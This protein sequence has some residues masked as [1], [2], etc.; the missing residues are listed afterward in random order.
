[1]RAAHRPDEPRPVGTALTLSL[2]GFGGGIRQVWTNREHQDD[3]AEEEGALRLGHCT[4]PTT[5]VVLPAHA[6][7]GADNPTT[8]PHKSMPIGALCGNRVL[9]AVA[10]GRRR[11]RIRNPVS[12]GYTTRAD[13]EAAK[14][15]GSNPAAAPVAPAARTSIAPA[16]P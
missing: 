8:V 1:Q 13:S 15:C 3:Q 5:L 2:R 14:P 16:A 6:C 12:G 9:R 10:H 11:R 4:P 7:A